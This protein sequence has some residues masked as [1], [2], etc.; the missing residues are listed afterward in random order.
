MQ[1]NLERPLVF[2][3]LETTGVNVGKDRIVE[4]AML[5]IMPDGSE[6][7]KT[8]L[9]NPGVPIPIE[10]SNIHGIKD[11]DVKDK[12]RFPELAD[13]LLEFIENCDL[14]GYNSNKFDIP[15]LAEE[16]LRCGRDL[17]ITNRHLIDVQ[18]I[19]HKMEQR[20]LVAAYRFYCQKELVDAHHAEADTRATYEILKAQLDKYKD[21]EYVER[22]TGTR[23]QPVQ[24]NMRSLSIFSKEFRHVDLAGHIIYNEHD[25]EVFNFGKYKGK[26]VEW[27]FR[28]ESPYYDWMMKTDFPNYTK[29][30][31]TQI[32]ERIQK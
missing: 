12:P 1:L 13:E 21:M 23:S 14:A 24:N 25:E 19:F 28:H 11:I 2:F 26:T 31:I 8:W 30:I 7:K 5:K 3:D 22:N 15:L 10:V 17:D 18:N 9:V 16:L 4:I 32:K 6:Q 27:V 29:K 20:T